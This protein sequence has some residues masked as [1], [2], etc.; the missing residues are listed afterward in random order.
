MLH[1][2]L[3]EYKKIHLEAMKQRENVDKITKK[4]VLEW[5]TQTFK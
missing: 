3:A 1:F 2:L 5:N 4:C